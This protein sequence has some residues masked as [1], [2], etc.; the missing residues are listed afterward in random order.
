MAA[1][2]W[3]GAISFGLVN[4]PVTLHTAVR[5][6]SI[7]FRMLHGKDQC[8]IQF[9]RVCKKTGKEVPWDEI[10]KGYEYAKEKYVVLTDE[11]MDQ[12]ANAMQAS[13]AFAIED[14]VK[15]E[16]IDPRYF[17]KPYY[18][19]PGAGAEK[20]YA[21]LREAM[22]R[23]GTVGIGT[24]TLR[25][26]QYLAA[27]K[28]V[29][30]ALVLDMMRFAHEVV[31]Q[32]EFRFPSAEGIKPQEMKMAEQLIANLTEEFNPE[33]YRDEYRE[34]LMQIINAKLKGKKVTLEEAGEPEPTPVIDLMARLQ[35]SLDQG[36]KGKPA[37]S[38]AGKKA[39]KSRKS[40]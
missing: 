38:K 29:E 23:A 4:I 15:E 8:R 33:K 34:N 20:S 35:E 7:S 10:V 28:V 17:E 31:S 37:K 21:L 32:R 18:L 27:I 12:A 40:A 9:K 6:E 25:K 19:V 24:I 3:K 11:E 22:Q 39:T 13:K 14:F 5:D 2:I 1:T 30:D 36:G 26:K 16:E